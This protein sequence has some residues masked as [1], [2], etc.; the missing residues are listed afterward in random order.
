MKSSI[1]YM[2]DTIIKIYNAT[3]NA[4][5]NVMNEYIEKMSYIVGEIMRGCNIFYD[6]EGDNALKKNYDTTKVA[7]DN[8][9]IM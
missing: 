7:I 4:K 3:F 8:Q 9:L 6:G 2:F 1:R 5:M